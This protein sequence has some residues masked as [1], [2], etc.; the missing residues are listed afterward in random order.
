MNKAVIWCEVVCN[1]CG[2]TIGFNYQNAKTISALKN[3][4]RNW[5]YVGEN[6]N[7]CPEC[8]KKYKKEIK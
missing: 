4:S 1:G 2:D 6:G 5:V 8:Y 3:A 7:L